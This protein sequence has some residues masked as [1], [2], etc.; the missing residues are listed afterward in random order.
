MKTNSKLL[1][2]LFIA[3]I[4]LSTVSRTNAQPGT[5]N[6]KDST[7][8][9]RAQFQTNMMKSKLK[10]DSG[11]VS[12]IREINLKYA[13][14]IQPIITGSDGRFSKMKQAMALQK[15]KDS[16]LQ[17]VFSKDQYQQ[18]QAFE[19]EMKNK[20]TEKLKQN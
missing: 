16:E 6:M 14:K 13:K 4:S 19:Q 9:E 12:K 11:Q 15:Q 1:V 17:N 3:A 20:L 8:E 2:I 18:Y 5:K 10:L 7:P